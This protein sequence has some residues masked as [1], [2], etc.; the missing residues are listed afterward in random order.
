MNRIMRSVLMALALCWLLL[1]LSPIPGNADENGFKGTDLEPEVRPLLYA[2]EVPLTVAFFLPETLGEKHRQDIYEQLARDDLSLT[3]R[4][5]LLYWG[6]NPYTLHIPDY[7]KNIERALADAS[8]EKLSAGWRFYLARCLRRGG[9]F[10][11]SRSDQAIS[12]WCYLEAE[13]LLATAINNEPDEAVLRLERATLEYWMQAFARKYPEAASMATD[14][15]WP[16]KAD[17]FARI[18][19]FVDAPQ[20]TFLSAPPYVEWLDNPLDSR[21]LTVQA[22]I[23]WMGTDGLEDLNRIG[24]LSEWATETEDWH[25]LDL[26]A[27]FCLKYS[28]GTTIIPG[29][30]SKGMY[31]LSN[32]LNKY[33]IATERQ[34]KSTHL[35]VLREYKDKLSQLNAS[36]LSIEKQARDSRIAK[37]NACYD[38]A[39][40]S[41][42]FLDFCD[43]TEN[44]IK[45]DIQLESRTVEK[46]FSE[47]RKLVDD[48]RREWR[49]LDS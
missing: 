49:E 15:A 12:A 35:T 14:C 9:F 28:E 19:E 42:S 8:K 1:P 26:L 25:K 5:T 16:K 20:Y 30:F 3:S 10:Y 43:S 32:V 2:F 31:M 7:A 23:G 17:V 44:D 36:V 47:F 37:K 38:I 24:R 21:W 40:I 13:K 22:Q 33:I 41:S 6:S 45:F 4:I 29:S 48:L 18:Q 46:Y 11:Y 39:P 27:A 34:G